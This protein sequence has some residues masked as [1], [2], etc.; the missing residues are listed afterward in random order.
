MTNKLKKSVIYAFSKLDN[1]FVFKKME[2][3]SICN[4]Q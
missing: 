4:N 2:H 1:G 3:E